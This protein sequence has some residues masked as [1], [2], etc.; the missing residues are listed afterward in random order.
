MNYFCASFPIDQE[1]NEILIAFLSQHGFE[2]F[3]E[4]TDG[5]KAFIPAVDVDES[6]LRTRFSAIPVEILGRE[7]TI[8]LLPDQNWNAVWESSF[9]PVVVAEKISIRAPFHAAP[10]PHVMDII[11]EPK[12]SFG[13][14]HHATTAL[15]IEAMLLIDWKGAVVLDMG[16]GSGVLAIVAEKSGAESILAIDIDDWAVENSQENGLR[17]NCIRITTLK[18]NASLLSGKTFTHILANI[19]R[20]ILLH[21]MHTYVAA[22]EIDGLL[23]MSGFLTQ[24]R[25]VITEKARDLGLSP[26][27]SLEHDNWA[28]L[29]F[30]N[31]RS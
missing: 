31:T 29:S 8:E 21:D 2:M 7:W 23:F 4:Q 26:M 22:L 15:M 11:I 14:G 3:E 6:E 24:D 28:M 20:N 12:M 19:N 27:Q 5:L 10:P 13:T 1:N 25:E 18:G 17:N 16:C 9:S 30:K